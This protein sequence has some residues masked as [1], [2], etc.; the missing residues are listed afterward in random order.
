M[1]KKKAYRVKGGESTDITGPYLPQK[2]Y[3]LN[4]TGKLNNIKKL[5][6][7]NL[8]KT[9]EQLKN[10]TKDLKDLRD[11][12]NDEDN[13]NLKLK[14]INNKK[15]IED[16]KISLQVRDKLYNVF[17][18]DFAGGIFNNLKELISTVGSVSYNAAHLTLFGGE[19]IILKIICI[20]LAI[21]AFVFI[22]LGFTGTLSSNDISTSSDITKSIITNDNELNFLNYNSSSIFSRMSN[23]LYNLV[24]DEYKYKFN[25]LTN[26]L[27][28]VT[29]GKNKYEDYLINREEIN[30]GRNDNIFHIIHENKDTTLCLLK[31]K[32]IK[33]DFPENYYNNIDFNNIN[34]DLRKNIKYP[35][36]MEIPFTTQQ[37]NNGLKYVLDTSNQ[38]YYNIDNINVSSNINNHIF[39]SKKKNI[40]LNSFANKLY[41]DNSGIIAIYAPILLTSSYKG[42]IMIIEDENGIYRNLYYNIQ[43]KNLYYKD[44]NINKAIDFSK[45]TYYGI[46]KLFDQTENGHHYIFDNDNDMDDKYKPML[47][48]KNNSYLIEFF[49]RSILYLSKPYP[50][51]KSS[52]TASIKFNIP[53][54]KF[55]RG[56]QYNGNKTMSLLTAIDPLMQINIDDIHTKI[57][58]FKENKYDFNKYHVI[59][60]T[61]N[62]YA[63]S[64]L[65]LSSNNE[66]NMFHGY[67]KYLTI[68]LDLNKFQ[69][70]G[71]TKHDKIDYDKL[72]LCMK[73]QNSITSKIYDLYINKDNNLVTGTN[74]EYIIYN[75]G[76]DDIIELYDHNN[77]SNSFKAITQDNRY[78]PNLEYNNGNFEIRFFR[79][80]VLKAQFD[81]EM[82]I[83][84]IKAKINI[85]SE[86]CDPNPNN[87]TESYQ[88]K[89]ATEFD[90]IDKY[91][92]LLATKN[93][94]IIKLE[95]NNEDKY[96]NEFKYYINVING[97]KT[98]SIYD[99]KKI[100]EINI[101]LDNPSLIECLGVAHD[102]R[103]LNDK[104]NHVTQY[105]RE[106]VGKKT[107]YIKKHAFIG[108]LD[109]L[110]ISKRD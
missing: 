16:N 61:I 48:N 7:E 43:Y 14:E 95:F 78:I 69:H 68:N 87:G 103:S 52:I 25:S 63:V 34:E 64:S 4:Y 53:T 6:D 59:T 28:Y 29:T 108:F 60:N 12:Q 98:D 91:M 44:D 40:L 11:A 3:D 66:N 80:S 54:E 57:F 90:N 86:N 79:K 74:S 85:E 82:I 73:V 88:C 26:S 75:G 27:S 104:T 71:L 45:R 83:K 70:Y 84:N 8:K 99:S 49:P 47:V 101:E 67:L 81:E 18:K 15:K 5:Y 65:Y 23:S 110:I 72:K 13:K 100:E 33:I 9:G 102:I 19:G 94:S 92:D 1:R 62:N 17:V 106:S 24:P 31:P 89:Y 107:D 2:Y 109:K 22:I 30:T 42:P 21:V 97:K 58:K 10:V 51:I 20:I 38:Q 39:I 96:K 93:S 32:E 77:S 50:N 37:V 35:I 76:Y 36:L 56:I 46:K 105:G 41:N 55:Q